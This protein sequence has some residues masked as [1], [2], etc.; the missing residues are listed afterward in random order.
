MSAVTQS[1]AQ[2]LAGKLQ[3]AYGER[4]GLAQKLNDLNAYILRLE[5]AYVFVQEKLKEDGQDAV[6]E[7]VEA[8]AAASVPE[9]QEG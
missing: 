6:Q 3:Q 7:I 4:D 2:D 9:G 5:G 1:D 8:E